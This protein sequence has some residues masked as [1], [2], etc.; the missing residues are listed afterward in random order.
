MMKTVICSKCNHIQKTTTKLDRVTCSNCGYKIIIKGA[1][2]GTTGS[3][4]TNRGEEVH[5]T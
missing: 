4:A 2:N 5:N 3:D 1:E